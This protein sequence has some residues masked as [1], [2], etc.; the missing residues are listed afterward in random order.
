[1]PAKSKIV[2]V[3]LS[4]SRIAR[5]EATFARKAKPKVVPS[6]DAYTEMLTVRLTQ[7]QM[8]ELADANTEEYGLGRMSASVFAREV[9]LRGLKVFAAEA[10]DR[11]KADRNRNIEI[12]P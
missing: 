6:R 8:K 4:K 1:M 7:N 10:W 12:S 5:M 9:L 11:H 3:E 2:P